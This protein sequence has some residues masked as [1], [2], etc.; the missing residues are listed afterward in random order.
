MIY[1]LN[2][3]GVRSFGL[4]RAG[5]LAG[6][7]EKVT[8]DYAT[9]QQLVWGDGCDRWTEMVSHGEMIRTGYDQR[10]EYDAE[11]PSMLIQGLFKNA[12]DVPYPS[13]PWKLGVIRRQAA[14]DE[15]AYECQR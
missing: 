13:L 7:W 9:G 5:E 8:D 6:P 1:E 14:S 12:M 3:Q 11:K 2:H 4:A 15:G 10:L